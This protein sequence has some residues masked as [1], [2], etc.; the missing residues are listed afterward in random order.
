M[1][2]VDVKKSP[3]VFQKCNFILIWF[4]VSFFL[5]KLTP[6]CRKEANQKGCLPSQGMNHP[7]VT[8]WKQPM[9]LMMGCCE[10]GGVCLSISLF[11]Y[12]RFWFWC[13][14][15]HASCAAPAIIFYLI[16]FVIIKINKPSLQ[17]W[18]SISIGALTLTCSITNWRP[19]FQHSWKNN[20]SN[21]ETKAFNF[22]HQ[23]SLHLT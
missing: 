3:F 20:S 15:R 19:H 17:N 22:I 13:R 16:D 11:I 8:L 10:G 4:F 9:S 7:Y 18:F 5:K 23:S 1:Q 14:L 21:P 12:E 6:N 2:Y